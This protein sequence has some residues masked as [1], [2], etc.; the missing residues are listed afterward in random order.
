MIEKTQAQALR[1]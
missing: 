1:N